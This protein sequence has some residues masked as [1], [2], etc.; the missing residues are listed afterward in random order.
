MIYIFYITAGFLLIRLLVV[1][2]NILSKPYLQQ[3]EVKDHSALISVLIPARNEENNI[4]SVLNQLKNQS[5]KNIEIIVLDDDSEDN[6]YKLA[7]DFFTSNAKI[8][9]GQI[10]QGEKLPAGWLGKNWACHQLALKAKGQYFLFVDADVILAPEAIESA[11]MQVRKNALSLLS[12]FPDQVLKT[13]GEKLVVPFM[14]YILLT[15][16]P[17]RLIYKSKNPA[18]SA[19]NG[20][21][22]FFQAKDYKSWHSQLKGAVTEDIE[23]LRKM[24]TEGFKT[25]TLLGNKL[26]LCRMYNSFSDALEGFS[27]NIFA[28]FGNNIVFI[29]LYFLLTLVFPVLILIYLPVNFFIVVAI[30]ALLLKLG[31]SYL[32][33]YDLAE[34]IFLHFF[35]VFISL[36]LGIKSVYNTYTRQN[37][38]KGRRI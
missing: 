7:T 6:T 11:Y 34:Q 19:A 16:L 30:L 1:F 31:V 36:W 18:F 5:Y 13:I 2:A 32:A 29:S 3:A 23:I 17:L 20:Q 9:Q 14:H 37:K 24:K 21:F 15:L 22:M 38:W 33:K 10:I 25:E 27:K 12:L 8:I 4:G 28:G 35:Q 26:V